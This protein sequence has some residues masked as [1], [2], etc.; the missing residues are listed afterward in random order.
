MKYPQVY[1]QIGVTPPR[2][3]LLH[4]PPGC[5]KTLMANAIAGVSAAE[6]HLPVLPIALTRDTRHLT[7]YHLLTHHLTTHHLL[8]YCSEYFYCICFVCCSLI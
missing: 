8:T 2:G 5:G 4:G 7:T 1:Q 3:F 6:H